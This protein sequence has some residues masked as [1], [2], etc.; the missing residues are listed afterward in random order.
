MSKLSSLIAKPGPQ[1]AHRVL[2]LQGGWSAEREV[3]LNSGRGVIGAL[4]KLGH[5][6]EAFDPP[7]DAH[8]ITSAIR[9]SF[10][11]HGPEVI[12][13]ILHGKEVEDGVLQGLLEL[14][15]IPYTFSGVSASAASMHKGLSRSLMHDA[16][17]ACPRGDVMHFRD[18]AASG[19]RYPH[20]AKPVDEGSSVGVF[21][22]TGDKEHGDVVARWSHGD[23]VLVEDYIPGREIQVAI[24]GGRVMGAVELK[25][26]GPIFDYEAKYV[27]GV[28]RHIIPPV[29]PVAISE[30]LLSWA[31]RAYKVMGCRGV[32]RADFRYNPDGPK[33][34][35][36]F[37]L[38][39]N[40]QPG[41]TETSLV[42]DI[43]HFYGWSYEDVV[44]FT[45]DQAL[46][47]AKV[48]GS[49]RVPN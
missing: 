7:R 24:F 5:H 30:R 9:A 42:P 22:V 16:G 46:G 49:C 14:T 26:P 47:S 15:G 10:G 12:F 35:Q 25:F 36:V 44:A 33:D 18:Y 48:P 29:L 32:A 6:V 40:T 31:E 37:L 4:K 11:G 2:V 34:K 3:S 23:I 43:A 1:D 41:F 17:I 28:T 45:L 13:N 21:Y 19:W 20:I 27:P 39:I 8:A 38:E